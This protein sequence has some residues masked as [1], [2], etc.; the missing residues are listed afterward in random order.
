MTLKEYKNDDC[1]IIIEGQY[2]K[3]DILFCE[4]RLKYSNQS[5]SYKNIVYLVNEVNKLTDHPETRRII[6]I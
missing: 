4:C 6:E 5:V 2:K 3:D 1:K